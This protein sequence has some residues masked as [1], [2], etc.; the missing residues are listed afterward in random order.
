[1]MAANQPSPP[2]SRSQ[3]YQIFV[4]NLCKL[5]YFLETTERYY[6]QQTRILAKQVRKAKKESRLVETQLEKLAGRSKLSKG[7]L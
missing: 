1:M 5:A 4:S 2:A 7:F 3:P 6:G